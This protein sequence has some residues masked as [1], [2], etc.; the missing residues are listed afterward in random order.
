MSS[1]VVNGGNPLSGR[2]RVSGAKNS[3][4]PI[5]FSTIAAKG[6]S[7]I[8]NVPD[9][10]D[11]KTAIQLLWGFGAEVKSDADTLT[12][13]TRELKYYDPPE[14]LTTSLRASTYLIGATLARFGRANIG[15][16]GGCNFAP[17]PIDLHIYAMEQ[18]GAER[19]GNTLVLKKYKDS[20]ITFPKT[21]VGAT[22]NTLILAS[23]IEK[24][25]II[26]GC[27]IEPHILV[28]IEYL[29]AAGAEITLENR[30]ITVR[31]GELSRAEVTLNGDMIEAATYHVLSLL[32]GGGI[33]VDGVNMDELSVFNDTLTAA[34]ALQQKLDTGV[35]F[36]GEMSTTVD[37]I[38]SPHPGFAT[39]LCPISAPLLAS[40][41]GGSIR[42]L[43]F[44]TRFGY[45]LDLASFGL[46]FIRLEG[47]VYILPSRIHPATVRAPDLRGGMAALILALLARGESRIHSAETI[48]RGYSSLISKLS[49]LGAKID[50]FQ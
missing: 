28:L 45:L 20:H 48:L 35:R 32:L 14:N 30:R 16:Y 27:A 46:S 49:S 21:S 47:G 50:F 33:I 25:T 7:K 9:I 12:V 23:S 39:D 1:F 22:V 13:D 37:I 6:I 41:N 31:G 44:P 10:G 2:V 15:L 4:L 38:A 40:Y 5:L 19:V 43:V 42:D 8:Y 11:V 34:G 36:Y 18:M 3:A 26:D 24:T 17:R 29:R